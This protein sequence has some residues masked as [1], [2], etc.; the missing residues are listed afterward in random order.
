[1]ASSAG[2]LRAYGNRRIGGVWV[3]WD[4]PPQPPPPP[5]DEPLPHEEPLLHEE[6]LL[7]EDELTNPAP[8][9]ADFVLERVRGRITLAGRTYG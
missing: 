6:T 5:Q 3:F 4:Y 8:I 1:M 9:A 7:Q 2:H